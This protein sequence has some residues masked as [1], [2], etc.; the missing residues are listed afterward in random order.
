MNR[1]YGKMKRALLLVALLLLVPVAA[2]AQDGDN[3]QDNQ[4]NQENAQQQ[5]DGQVNGKYKD[6]DFHGSWSLELQAKAPD[7]YVHKD[8]LGNR[9]TFI[10]TIV[11]IR[12]NFE[13]TV[14][15]MLNF[16]LAGDEE[17]Y[18]PVTSYPFVERQV[19]EREA[20]LKGFAKGVR[21]E[22]I[23]RMKK[24]GRFLNWVELHRGYVRRK[25]LDGNWIKHDIRQMTTM[26]GEETGGKFGHY[27]RPGPSGREGQP[28]PEEMSEHPSEVTAVLLFR[29]V[30]LDTR[31]LTLKVGGLIDPVTWNENP[32][33]EIT[34]Q[35]ILRPQTLNIK[36]TWDVNRSLKR[37]TK[38]KFHTREMVK[39]I[40]G[41]IANPRT[42]RKLIDFIS[43]EDH[44]KNSRVSLLRKS[45]LR[46][47]RELTQQEFG[48]D[49][50]KPPSENRKAI[51][52]WNEWYY[53]N[54]YDLIY[55]SLPE[56]QYASHDY[57]QYFQ[58]IK[59]KVDTEGASNPEEAFTKFRKAWNDRKWQTAVDIM[60]LDQRDA[61]TLRAMFNDFGRD[62]RIGFPT[63]VSQ[64][65]E[66]HAEISFSLT[67]PAY[68]EPADRVMHALKEHGEW[69][70]RYEK[71]EKETPG[72]QD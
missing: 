61:E 27:L 12:N 56:S 3:N 30:D 20:N 31:N 52:R 62:N 69:F 17:D 67:G 65:D 49:P 16:A 34:K 14:P 13:R 11:T 18:Y 26:R 2:G 5:D 9:T 42:I 22:K 4:Q 51:A 43:L 72:E 6:P 48:Y 32:E 68:E 64:T 70:I 35:Y 24:N 45:A 10:Y 21:G 71:P 23:L 66:T 63:D 50:Q 46:P 7:M 33:E 53:R 36:W 60:N 57:N 1:M 25:N 19:I 39:R 40:F 37:E 29:N 38:P 54:K 15:V 55:I 44:G 59:K 41:P 8:D 47:L 58:V 28:H